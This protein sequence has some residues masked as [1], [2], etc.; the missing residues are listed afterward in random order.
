MKSGFEFLYAHHI[1]LFTFQILSP[2]H[3]YPFWIP[4]YNPVS[5]SN[6]KSRFLIAQLINLGSLPR[7]LNKGP[8][9]YQ[10]YH[11]INQ[12]PLHMGFT[13]QFHQ[14][15][16]TYSKSSH[17]WQQGW[18]LTWNRCRAEIYNGCYACLMSLWGFDIYRW[19]RLTMWYVW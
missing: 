15:P 6:R 7:K 11:W 19:V 10:E 2:S 9:A 16:T 4:Q 3:G 1:D 18:R 12:L 14:E 5:N 13:P 8:S 17:T